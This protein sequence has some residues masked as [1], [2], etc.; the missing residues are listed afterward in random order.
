[1]GMSIFFTSLLTRL[2]AFF[3]SLLKNH[4]KIKLAHLLPGYTQRLEYVS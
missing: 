1:M 3:S 2:K 4:I